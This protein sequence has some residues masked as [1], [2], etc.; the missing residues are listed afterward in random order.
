MAKWSNENN[1]F[2]QQKQGKHKTFFY[3]RE[4]I[5]KNK[6]CIKKFLKNN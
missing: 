6:V 4:N 5:K 3:K 1:F 2:T